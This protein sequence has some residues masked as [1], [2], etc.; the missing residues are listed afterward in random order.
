MAPDRGSSGGE[1]D[2]DHADVFFDASSSPYPPS[3][4]VVTP[5]QKQRA[6]TQ[7]AGALAGP[8][9]PSTSSP[10][11]LPRANFPPLGAQG[12][13]KAAQRRRRLFQHSSQTARSFDAYPPRADEL[14]ERERRRLQEGEDGAEEGAGVESGPRQVSGMSS[15]VIYDEATKRVLNT[16]MPD[17][18]RRGGTRTGKHT[19]RWQR[20][21]KDGAPSGNDGS[22]GVN[23]EEVVTEE[24]DLG[25]LPDLP[26]ERLTMERLESLIAASERQIRNRALDS[27]LSKMK[28]SSTAGDDCTD[29]GET[30]E[31]EEEEDVLIQE[32]R[33]AF[34]SPQ[35]LKAAFGIDNK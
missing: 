17:I 19:G 4:A 35:H 8:S 25:P 16:A 2:D 11:A 7:R 18:Y 28:L 14:V 1:E 23:A 27:R 9:G 22:S 10:S 12:P 30:E 24:V 26:A 13:S 5:Q 6:W 29:A 31:E 33:K 3:L 20:T 34:C 15:V 21:A 32:L